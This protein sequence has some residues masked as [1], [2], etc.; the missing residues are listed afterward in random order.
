[1]PE[2]DLSTELMYQNCE[3]QFGFNSIYFHPHNFSGK[4]SVYL[5]IICPC[6]HQSQICD[7][8]QEL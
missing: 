2:E 4:V 7:F 6:H 1:M 8:L 5:D 3:F